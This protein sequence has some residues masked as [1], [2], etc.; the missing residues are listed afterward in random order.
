MSLSVPHCMDLIG[1]IKAHMR[2]GTAAVAAVAALAA[3][4]YGQFGTIR[5]LGEL[6]TPGSDTHMTVS[7]D[8]LRCFFSTDTEPPSSWLREIWY[9]DRATIGDVFTNLQK[10]PELNTTSADLINTLSATELTI[11]KTDTTAGGWD[12]YEATRPSTVLPFS[13]PVPIPSLSTP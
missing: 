12:L 11:I 5:A 7:R 6:N 1:R 8:N 4:A 3:P 2:V 10:V 9:A 13:T